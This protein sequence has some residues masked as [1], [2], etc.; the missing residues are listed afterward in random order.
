M[1]NLLISLESDFD[2]T[3]HL[4]CSVA[5][6]ESGV[7]LKASDAVLWSAESVESALRCLNKF[8]VS[9]DD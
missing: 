4:T 1:L 2:T 5:R 3:D 7:D 6:G 9:K 8:K